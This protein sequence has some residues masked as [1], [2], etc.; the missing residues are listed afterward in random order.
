M[1]QNA[2]QMT[3]PILSPLKSSPFPSHSR[4]GPGRGKKPP[5]SPAASLAS[6]G[7]TFARAAPP[8]PLPQPPRRRTQ[9][10]ERASLLPRLTHLEWE[11]EGR[12][13]SPEVPASGGLWDGAS[14]CPGL[15]VLGGSWGGTALG[16][17]CP[18]ASRSP[19]AHVTAPKYPTHFLPNRTL[20]LQAG[21][22]K[23]FSFFFSLPTPPPPSL[24]S[25][26]LPLPPSLLP[27]LPAPARLPPLCPGAGGRRDGWAGGGQGGAA[28]DAWVS[29]PP[30]C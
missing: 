25:S 14:Q 1:H 16:W 23:I 11:G 26:L 10:T 20:T 15:V 27:P 2:G 30:I 8:R 3:Q 22:R 17:D 12:R 13:R 7:R 5:S 9:A 19:P 21:T 29:A 4:A 18:G 6:L 28:R 24:P